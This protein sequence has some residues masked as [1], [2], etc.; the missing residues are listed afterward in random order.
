MTGIAAPAVQAADTQYFPLFT[1]RTGPYAPNGIPSANGIADYF[2]YV[3]LKHGGV[4]GV[5]LVWE[6][7]ET[8]YNT[9]KG[10]E[11]YER[12]KGKGTTVVFPYS[13]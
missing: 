6:E 9:K 11:C 10:V 5:K 12:L 13:T 2:N 3:N 4:N 7:C 1:Y 8:G